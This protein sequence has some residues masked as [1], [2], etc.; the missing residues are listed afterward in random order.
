M[1]MKTT[2]PEEALQVIRTLME[3]ATIY[4]RALRPILWLAG[5]GAL[6]MMVMGR[7]FGCVKSPAFA[8]H[9]FTGGAVVA[10]GALLLSRI[11]ALR[12][13][14]HFW[15]LPAR[16][17][18]LALAAPLLAAVGATAML[19]LGIGVTPEWLVVLWSLLYGCALHAAGFLA[20]RGLQ[21]LGWAFLGYGISVAGCSW[22]RGLSPH[23]LMGISFGGL[24]LTY[25]LYL[26]ITSRES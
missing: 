20:P 22:L 4:Q 17:V 8:V 7:L 1:P 5:V 12:E 25:A 26:T 21:K 15:S 24:H 2:N 9:W 13:R 11:H 3:R 16:R 23:L 6:L 18:T 10:A 19:I 14:E